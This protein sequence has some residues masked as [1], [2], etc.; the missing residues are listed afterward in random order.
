MTVPRSGTTVHEKPDVHDIV[1]IGLFVN[2]RA[3]DGLIAWRCRRPNGDRR[4]K[5]TAA[6]FY[7]TA[8]G[9]R[10]VNCDVSGPLSPR[11][12]SSTPTRL[13]EM[14]PPLQPGDRDATVTWPDRFREKY[15]GLRGSMLVTR[16]PLSV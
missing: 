5:I 9:D 8:P 2:I 16:F 14:R 3:L 13:P 6:R 11:K 7:I 1:N 4:P 12:C 15:S 10:D